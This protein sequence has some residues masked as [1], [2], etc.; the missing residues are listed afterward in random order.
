MCLDTEIRFTIM[1]TGHPMPQAKMSPDELRA[2]TALGL[3]FFLRMF[4]L[5]LILPVFSLYAID[6]THATATLVGLAL[7]IYGL[8]QALFQIPFGV[9]SDKIGRKPV[10]ISGLLLF[11]VGSVIAALASDIYLM[12]I[13]RALQGAGAIASAIIAF[14]SDLVSPQHRTKAM[15]LI[16]MSI[17]IAFCTA[18]V[19]G[20]V[21][22]NYIGF[23]GL[24]YLTAGLGL[25]GIFCLRFVPETNTAYQ[26]DGGVNLAEIKKVLSDRLLLMFDLG[27]FILHMVLTA[28]FVIVPVLLLDTIGIETAQHWQL[29]LPVM[30]VSIM[31]MAPFVM[32]A[33]RKQLGPL[34]YTLMIGVLLIS[35]ISFAFLE[36]GLW[37]VLLNMTLFF[38][39][40]NFLE[41]SLPSLISK[42]VDP[43]RKGTA[44]GIYSTSQ[45]MGA[46]VGGLC[47][48]YLFGAIGYGAVFLFC[49]LG[50]AAWWSIAWLLYPVLQ[51]GS[52]ESTQAHG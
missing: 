2:S 35:Q 40:F 42:S 21:L 28:N 11:M 51:R 49:A 10:I 4:G 30:L 32:V 5:F 6:Y 22:S 8:T 45:F 18:F 41:A 36:L 20:P 38:V 16:G 52:T 19:L 48:G 1:T 29:Y 17:G 31:L 12:I 27:I 14:T 9:L 13:G 44:L 33:D 50:I 37:T 26:H 34:L 24:F 39:A 25:T 46:F 47:G 23:S 3:I 7:G 15:A 43:R